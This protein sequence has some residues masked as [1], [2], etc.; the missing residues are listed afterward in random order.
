[1]GRGKAVGQKDKST[2]HVTG[3]GMGTDTRSRDTGRARVRVFST[4]VGHK[5]WCGF[6]TGAQ[7][8]AQWA[9][10]AT[11]LSPHLSPLS[12]LSPTH[13]RA[14]VWALPAAGSCLCPGSH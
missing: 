1:M 10:T 6:G 9:H 12:T 3:H 5:A 11:G 8:G 2:G 7:A 14:V 13:R 4:G